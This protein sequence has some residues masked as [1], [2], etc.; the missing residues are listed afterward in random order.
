MEGSDRMAWFL[1]MFA[2]QPGR[3]DLAPGVQVAQTSKR[4]Q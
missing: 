3:K 2:F 4:T 1:L